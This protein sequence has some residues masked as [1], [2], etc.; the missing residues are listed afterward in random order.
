MFVHEDTGHLPC[1]VLFNF[2][3]KVVHLNWARALGIL[4]F[5]K[6]R[7]HPASQVPWR[8]VRWWRV[9]LWP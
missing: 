8:F 9:S 2:I 6:A 5:S 1:A 3:Y 7:R 4:G